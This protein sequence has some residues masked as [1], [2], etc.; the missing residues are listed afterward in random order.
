MIKNFEIMKNKNFVLYWL[1]SWASALGD[2][3]FTI[4]VSWWIV[5]EIG[6][7]LV[8]GT[9][10]L[11]MGTTRSLFML[12][13]G[14]MVDRKSPILLMKL[15]LLTRAATMCIIIIVT[16]FSDTY[17]ILYIIAGIYGIVDAVFLPAA[18][19]ARQRL[20]AKEYYTQ[21]NSLLLL[22]SQVSVIIGP[23]IGAFL[24]AVIGFKSL[25]VLITVVFV[26]AS[27]ALQVINL[28]PISNKSNELSSKK[29]SFKQEILEGFSYVIRT[30]IILTNIIVAMIVNAGVSVLTVALPFL[31]KELNVGVKGL[32]IMTSGMGIGGTVGAIVFSLWIIKYPTPRMNYM[33]CA[34]EGLA[35]LLIFFTVTTWQVALLLAIVGFTTTA[36]NVIAPSVNQ[37]II[38]KELFGRVVSVMMLAMTGTIP[39]SQALAGYLIDNIKS[40]H[41]VFIYGGLLEILAGVIAL[42]IPA[43][44][45]YKVINESNNESVVKKEG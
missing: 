25:F 45:F 18:A 30:P 21:L 10:L 5:Q 37:S 40:V 13:G 42:S 3:I 24:I 19:A 34:L 11:I 7:A 44:R 31:A 29:S 15:S 27:L 38:P 22:A 36:I 39:V 1:A 6:S 32:S 43:V 2:A 12:F 4:G 28:L 23:V 16:M 17:I 8:M 41:Q 33:V 35:V 14:V 20:V 26:L 9:F